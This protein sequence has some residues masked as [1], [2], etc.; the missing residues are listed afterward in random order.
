MPHV[1]GIQANLISSGIPL[2]EYP[3][4]SSAP[5]NVFCESQPGQT[6]EVE[7]SGPERPS[8]C[9]VHL[10][11][12][13]V[14]MSGYAF[15]RRR[16]IKSTFRGVYLPGDDAALLP[17]KFAN[18]ELCEE[19]D[20][21]PEQIVKNLGTVAIEFFHCTLGPPKPSGRSTIP[22]VASN[23]KF[24]ERNKKASMIPHTIGLGESLPAP[25]K[26]SSIS[27]D[28]SQIDP[29]PYVR[30][31]WQYR[32]RSMLIT[33][34]LIPRPTSQLL[35]IRISTPPPL[36]HQDDEE[37]HKETKPDIKPKASGTKPVVIDLCDDNATFALFSNS[38]E[39]PILLDDD[40][41]DESIIQ[42]S[43]NLLQA[44]TSSST[45]QQV[46]N[47]PVKIEIDTAPSGQPN[48]M[49]RHQADTQV[50]EIDQKRV[51]LEIISEALN[52]SDATIEDENSV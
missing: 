14:F 12:D 51:K 31:V 45:T 46:D 10:Y 49:K 3:N 43:V 8:D 25:T 6:F 2:M 47:K 9:V 17:F 5:N 34:G 30:F 48:R 4:V 27:H 33:S 21:H 35:D 13:G 26:R 36:T 24:S 42:S 20:S 50:E 23:N 38:I 28:P 11:C 19:D 18:V 37:A 40:E 29:T 16:R 1:D 22:S 32:S 39:N 15:P 41:D 7:F 44:S 52:D